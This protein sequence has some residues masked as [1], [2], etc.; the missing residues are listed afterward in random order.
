MKHKTKLQNTKLPGKTFDNTHIQL[1]VFLSMRK[2]PSFLAPG[3]S[4]V[5]RE[6]PLW[7]GSE[8]GRLFSQAK[9]FYHVIW[10]QFLWGGIVAYIRH[11]IEIITVPLRS[12][13]LLNS[14]A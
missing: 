14:S 10:F 11:W 1:G 13:R 5:S 4:G 3:P 12:P 9:C 2:Q 6:T 8:E 7:A